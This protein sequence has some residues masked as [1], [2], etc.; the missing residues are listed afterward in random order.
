MSRAS[1]LSMIAIALAVLG[2]S[3]TAASADTIWQMNHP[4]REQVNN[5]LAN[6]NARIH[7]EVK[8]GDLTLGQAAALHAEDHAIRVE[9]RTFAGANGTHITP[10]E[11]GL[12]NQQE[13]AVSHQIRH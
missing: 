7:Q 9:E 12:L 6:Q 8:E 5:R 11:K 1:K 13:N 4:R 2:T 10:F 3:Y